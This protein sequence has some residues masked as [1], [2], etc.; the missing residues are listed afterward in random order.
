MDSGLWTSRTLRRGVC[1][2]VAAWALAALPACVTVTESPRAE[3]VSAVVGGLAEP[4]AGEAPVA[5]S[6]ADAWRRPE[7]WPRRWGQTSRGGGAP[8]VVQQVTGPFRV[9]RGSDTTSGLAE[10]ETLADIAVFI[11]GRRRE[12]WST[13]VVA[14]GERAFTFVP[15]T[16]PDK[17]PPGPTSPSLYFQFLSGEREPLGVGDAVRLQRSWLAYYDP[18]VP[19]TL[20]PAE[21][22]ARGLAVVLPGMF[23][24]PGPVVEQVVHNLRA[25]GWAVLRLLAHPSRFTE[26]A[27]FAID[28]EADLSAWGGVIAG[29]L[30]SRAAECAYAIEETMPRLIAQRPGLDG[31]PRLAFGL[32]GGAMV[33][34][35]VVAR[36]PEA[37][38]GA[39][40]VA[41]G[42]D[43]LSVVL[44][45]NYTEWI[46]AVQVRL[47]EGLR[48]EAAR[49]IRAELVRAY[50]ER[51]PLDSL[52]TAAALAG[53]PVLVLHG[54][55]DQAVPARLGEELWQR[56]GRPERWVYGSG[57]EVLFMT[58][59]WELRRVLA[60]I[61]ANVPAPRAPGSAGPSAEPAAAGRGGE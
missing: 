50:R 2:A 53:K 30:G 42:A 17:P 15:V 8:G 27:V 11:Q 55:G 12:W 60:W 22:P 26:R 39:V 44:D 58:L 40:L 49:A 41:G 23:G 5:D 46:D 18:A 14:E 6:V 24:T 7:T 10:R 43:F 36:N 20:P 33:L 56:L 13:T 9:R 3:P 32:S 4:V 28:P 52:Y 51:A 37:Y 57:H 34:P 54:S 21:R 16:G 59:P 29:V 61:D 38:A 25:D 35:T 31:L 48:P 19:T 47:P 1:S 45:S